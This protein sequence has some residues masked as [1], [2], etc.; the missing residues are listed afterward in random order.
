MKCSVSPTFTNSATLKTNCSFK[1]YQKMQFQSMINNHENRQCQMI[2]QQK[3]YIKLTSR[4][5]IQGLERYLVSRE[6]F[7]KQR[8]IFLQLR[9]PK[10][11]TAA[12]ISGRFRHRSF[13]P[14]P[15]YSTLTHLYTDSFP[16]SSPKS[17]EQN[18]TDTCKYS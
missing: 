1:S 2:R 3:S 8:V 5:G 16:S 7:T 13:M 10:S 15:R 17:N 6:S 11:R 9:M 12:P 4:R 14:P 18:T